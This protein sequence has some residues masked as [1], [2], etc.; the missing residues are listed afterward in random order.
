MQPR[1]PVLRQSTALLHRTQPPDPIPGAASISGR[2][3]SCSTPS[4]RRSPR[5]YSWAGAQLPPTPVAPH[6]S[7]V[8]TGRCSTQPP[9][10]PHPK[11]HLALDL[12]VHSTHR[13]THPQAILFWICRCPS[14]LSSPALRSFCFGS[15]DARGTGT[16]HTSCWLA[17][18]PPSEPPGSGAPMSPLAQP[19]APPVI[20]DKGGSGV[21][22]YSGGEPSLCSA[23]E[24][25]PRP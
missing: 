17:P 7:P 12:P 2:A 15:A 13:P 18:C 14:P 10:S 16:P 4:A 21:L 1:T 6:A 11:L 5:V 19:R 8:R 23:V 9:P 20:G 3:Q 22:L 25:Q 24:A